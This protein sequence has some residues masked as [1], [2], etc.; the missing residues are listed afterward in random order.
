MSNMDEA[1]VT[2]SVRIGIC[3]EILCGLIYVTAIITAL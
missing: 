1:F 3:R 2:A